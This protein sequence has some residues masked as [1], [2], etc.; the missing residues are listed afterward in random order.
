MWRTPV[1]VFPRSIFRRRCFS[2]RYSSKSSRFLIFTG[3]DSDSRI[4][5]RILHV[6]SQFEVTGAEVYAAVLSRRQH[7]LGHTIFI[8]S[9]TFSVPFPG[10]YI[11]HP[12]GVRS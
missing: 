1:P 8:V 9:D 10:T 12:I 11:P 5:M 7:D 6:L 4:R 3:R 2:D